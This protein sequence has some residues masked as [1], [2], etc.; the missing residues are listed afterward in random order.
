V[1]LFLALAA[2]LHPMGMLAAVPTLIYADVAWRPWWRW[3]RNVML[4]VWLV[5]F[6]ALAQWQGPEIVDD[7]FVSAK[8]P[9]IVCAVLLPYAMVWVGFL[10]AVPAT[11][12]VD[13]IARLGTTSRAARVSPFVFVLILALAP[14]GHVLAGNQLLTGIAYV[15]PVAV[16]GLLPLI[17]WVRF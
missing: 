4:G 15:F 1:G 12:N 16:L 7:I 8:F 11:F 3:A 5:S 10:L 6:V 17:V 14:T 13:V 9:G 2:A